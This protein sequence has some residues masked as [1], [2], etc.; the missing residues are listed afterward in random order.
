MRLIKTI[1]KQDG[2]LNRVEL[3]GDVVMWIWWSL[4]FGSIGGNI[5]V[6]VSCVVSLMRDF[7]LH[8]SNWLM[9]LR[10]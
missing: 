7:V 3:S 4:R 8:L 2:V 5:Y 6:I 10:L 1:G 9:V